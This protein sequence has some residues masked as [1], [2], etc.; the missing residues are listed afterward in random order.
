MFKRGREAG[1]T[2]PPQAPYSP[3][4]N[5]SCS[6]HNH[7]VCTTLCTMPPSGTACQPCVGYIT[8]FTDLTPSLTCVLPRQVSA[9]CAELEE[10][11]QLLSSTGQPGVSPTLARQISEGLA[12][13]QLRRILE[14]LSLPLPHVST[15][16]VLSPPEEERRHALRCLRDAIRV[17]AA[18]G[19]E[20]KQSGFSASG[21]GA[22]SRAG[23]AGVSG[24]RGMR[25]ML[26]ATAVAG[27]SVAAA[28]LTEEFLETAV[29]QLSSEEL[30]HLQEWES[31]AAGRAGA[32]TW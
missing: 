17:A 28:V 11:F 30:V 24:S 5:T 1:N 25:S 7:R 21:G 14:V 10:A 23:R 22:G 9:G 12:S 18:A 8:P 4:S 6:P 16:S 19:P 2:K 31:V 32:Q 3:A 29:E 15:T 20:S 13:I 26:H 27:P